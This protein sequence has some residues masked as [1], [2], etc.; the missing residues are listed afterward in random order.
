MAT[1]PK[2]ENRERV[3]GKE[4]HELL[5]FLARQFNS[6]QRNWKTFVKEAYAIGKGFERMHHV[7]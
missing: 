3:I 4:K 2:R 7:L 1:K 6:T 5:I